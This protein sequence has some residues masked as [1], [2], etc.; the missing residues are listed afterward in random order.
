MKFVNATSV[1]EK[2]LPQNF[3]QKVLTETVVA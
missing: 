1:T 3:L 2:W